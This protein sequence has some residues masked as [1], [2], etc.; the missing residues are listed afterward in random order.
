MSNAIM[1]LMLTGDG[2]RSKKPLR[3]TALEA[4]STIDISETGPVDTSYLVK[5][6]NGGSWTPAIGYGEVVLE[7][8]G[9]YVEY[10]NRNPNNLSPTTSSSNYIKFVMTGKID[11]SGNVMSLCNYSK[12]ANDYAFLNLFHTC[13]ALVSGPEI[14]ADEFGIQAT[15]DMY[16]GCSNLTYVPDFPPAKMSYQSC[17]G[18]FSSCSSLVKAPELPSI[19][20]ADNCYESMFIDCTGLTTPPSKL[21][22]MDL[23]QYKN[24]YLGMF[25]RCSKLE[26]AP[27]LPATKLCYRSYNGMF[28]YCSALKLA[29][30]LPATELAD[31]CY[32]RMFYYCSGLT[33]PPSILPA[34]NLEKNCYKEMFSQCGYLQSIPE[35]PATYLNK[36]GVY[37]LM[38]SYCGRL[39]SVTLPKIT[40]AV[41]GVMNQMFNWC[42]RLN[43]IKIGFNFWTDPYSGQNFTDNWVSSV[44]SSGTFEGP[45]TLPIEFGTS[46]IPANWTVIGPKGINADNQTLYFWS[47]IAKENKIQY[48]AHTSNL[49]FEIVDG[50]LPTGLELT[51]DGKIKGT[52]NEEIITH[53]DVKIST[54][55]GSDIE[56][57]ITINIEFHEVNAYD[58]VFYFPCVNENVVYVKNGNDSYPLYFNQIS[59]SKPITFSIDENGINYLKIG[60]NASTYSN[61]YTLQAQNTSY[62]KFLNGKTDFTI[63]Y[64]LK[65]NEMFTS[66]NRN[67][68]EIRGGT[69]GKSLRI[70]IEYNS[71]GN[72]IF[73]YTDNYNCGDNNTFTFGSNADRALNLGQ[74]YDI[75]ITYESATKT[76]KCYIDKVHKTTSISNL[77]VAPTISYINIGSRTNEPNW[78][79]SIDSQLSDITIWTKVLTDE[80]IQSL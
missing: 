48:T 51:S 10:E 32:L 78:S 71:E 54:L 13:T 3:F 47:G 52:V 28:Q 77:D 20:L 6:I 69:G 41:T 72:F 50:S 43:Y 26:S 45:E 19:E 79:K 14:I 73:P 40:F 42:T 1:K 2:D 8:V 55:D 33:T 11:G 17:W 25:T 68:M 9:D 49:K 36:S 12:V 60:T 70:G 39:T 27:E 44:S 67:L 5:R 66:G 62:N 7:N 74:W 80:E 35:L 56:K 22:A 75:V 18:T 57:T 30:E 61:V 4:G 58:P 63:F 29:P 53:I 46:R 23:S 15:H 34:M 37:N 24:V 76:Y 38:F 65:V 16:W 59:T 21:P 64:K 31:E